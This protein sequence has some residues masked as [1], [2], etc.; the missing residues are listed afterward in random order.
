VDAIVTGLLTQLPNL[1]VAVWCIY[2]YQQTIKGL[3][4]QQNK[5]LDQ[6][7]LA[8]GL[9]VEQPQIIASPGTDGNKPI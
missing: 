2:N 6:L 9:K 3:L 1:A 7:L 5:L 8:K 4:D